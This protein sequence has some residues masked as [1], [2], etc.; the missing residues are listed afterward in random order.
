MLNLQ[1]AFELAPL[2]FYT[3]LTVLGLFIG[4]FLNVVAQRI[5]RGQSIVHP[6][7]HCESCGHRLGPLDLIPVFSWVLS[8]GKCRYC[9][10]KYAVGYALWEAATGG[11]FLLAGVV[12][13]PVPELITGLLLVSLLVVVVQTDL[14]GMVIPDRVV[15]FGM[16]AGLILR[17]FLHSRPL[18]D[19]GSAFLA[20][21]GLLFA[22]A[23]LG[24]KILSKEAMGGG[25]IK[26]LAMLGLYL[27]LAN[28]LL[29]LFIGS[30]LGLCLTLLLLALRRISRDQPIPFG[31]YLALGAWIA[32][33]WGSPM[34]QWYIQLV[35]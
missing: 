1:R 9:G 4:S 7:S 27:G 21:G 34:L 17:L 32:Y 11:L 33:L 8:A 19:Y 25:D 35:Q 2:Y 10:E 31:P 14:A 15:F 29:T 18:W 5:P 3:V 13:G 16:A 23:W 26:L 28:T 22:A 12:L 30:L 20:G 24:E 6:P